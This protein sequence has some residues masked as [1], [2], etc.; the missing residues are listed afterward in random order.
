MEKERE[1]ANTNGVTSLI[2]LTKEA[3]DTDYDAAIV[4]AMKHLAHLELCAAT[5]NASSC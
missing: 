3:T 1:R 5:H 2:Q 4:Q